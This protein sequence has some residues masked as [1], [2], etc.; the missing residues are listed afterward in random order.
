MKKMTVM[1][2]QVLMS[3]LTAGMFVFAFTACSDDNMESPVNNADDNQASVSD[4]NGLKKALGLVYTDFINDNDVQILNDD[5]TMISVSKAYA[6]KMGISDFVDHPMG[7]WQRKDE[8]SYLRRAVAQRLDGDKY[9]LN[10]VPSGLGEVLAGQEF[11]LNTAIYV[12]PNAGN[13][14]GLSADKYTDSQ[15]RIHP[16][17][18]AITR[19][20]GETTRGDFNQYGVLTAEEILNGENFDLSPTAKTR[21]NPLKSLG[22]AIGTVIDKVKEIFTVGSEFI[23]FVDNVRKNGLTVKGEN[24]GRFIREHGEFKFPK[25]EIKTGENKGDT[26]TIESKVP[27][28]VT[29]DYT[30]KL[31]SKVTLKKALIP[32]DLDTRYFEGRI[33][34]TVA[35]APQMMFG[36]NGKVEIP[37][38][39]QNI[40]LAQLSEFTFIFMAGC[41]PVAI[42]V[43]PAI[44]LHMNAGLS[45]QVYTGFKYE[46]ANQ[47]SAGVKY[48]KNNGGWKPIADYK[49]TKSEFSFIT[50]RAS[51]SANA[52]AGVLLGCDV[53]VDM[54]AGPT[55]SVGPLIKADMK[56]T[57]APMEKKPFEFEAGIKAGV[58]GRAG[59]KLKL[60]RVEL[61]EWQT[62]LNFG[63]EWDIWTFKFD[64]ENVKHSG[65]FAE[66][67]EEM[68]K[69]AQGQ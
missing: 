68:R 64:G 14:R 52:E 25:I 4:G 51:V 58:Y 57:I 17:A 56:A 10:V 3:T 7:I 15:N 63:P 61:L 27:Y 29:F 49:T 53:L 9:I 59:A 6:D 67:L 24:S 47:F 13:T 33:D 50:P 5:T 55:L 38:E 46:Y 32:F 66:Q 20:A 2:K 19:R 69:L 22:E 28:D 43:Q 21:W 11:E 34:G 30:L 60:W 35:V 44:Y 54:L 37:K 31:D 48:D 65:T 40:K 23:E 8:R 16:V 41:V 12:N 39:Y 18:V 1:V 62:E 26:L 45:G 42:T 36:L